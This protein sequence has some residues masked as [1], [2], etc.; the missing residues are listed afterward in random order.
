MIRPPACRPG[1][2]RA[3]YVGVLSP[4]A[5]AARV[6]RLTV[7]EMARVVTAFTVGGREKVRDDGPVTRPLVVRTADRRETQTSA[8]AGPRV[9]VTEDGLARQRPRPVRTEVDTEVVRVESAVDARR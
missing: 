7:Q 9:A 2:R 5:A 3:G 8:G 1:A 4:C 6:R